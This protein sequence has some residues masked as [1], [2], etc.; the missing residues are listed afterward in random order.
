MTDI[1]HALRLLLRRPLFT[2]TVVGVLALGI[3]ANTAI[4]SLVNAVLLRPLPYHD[5]NR[6]VFVWN[7]RAG[8]PLS[9]GSHGVLTGTHVIN[10]HEQSTS[11]ASIA[12]VDSWRYN[13]APKVDLVHASGAERLRGAFVT[14]NFFELL[15][16]KAELGRTLESSDGERTPQA[17]VLSDGFWR[18]RFGAD[19]N[20]IG[21]TIDV[22]AGRGAPRGQRLRWTIVGVLPPTFRYT[23]PLET[24]VWGVLPWTRIQPDRALQYEMIAR[25]RDGVTPAQARADLTAIVQRFTRG[26][27]VPEDRVRDVIA[28]VELAPEHLV[29]EARP[30]IMLLVAGSGVV[31]LIA[32]VNVALLLLALITDRRREVAVR[33]ALGA[34]TLRITKQLLIESLMIAGLGGTLGC[35]IAWLG[36]PALASLVAPIAPRGDEMTIDLVALAF[37]AALSLGIAL[38]CGL[39]PAWH[40]RSTDINGQLRGAGAATTV[41]P[42]MRRWRRAIV[43][44]QVAVV[45]MLLTAASLLL[46]SFWRMQQVDLGYESSGIVT[47]EMRLLHP[48]FRQPGRMAA[49]QRDVIDRVRALPGVE[50]ASMTSA[51]PL[52]G[53]DFMNN[54]ETPDGSRAFGHMRPIDP[55]Y[56][57]LMRIP[58][59]AGR[60]FTP[61]DNETSPR[62]AILSAVF[63]QQ[64]FGTASPLGRRVDLGRAFAEV[65]GVV[66]DVR[67]ADVTKPPLAAIYFPRPQ[68]PS[69][70]ICLVVRPRPGADDVANQVRHAVAA[71]DPEQPV[72]NVSTLDRI[73][74]ESTA[75]ERFYTA[76]TSGFALVA[77]ILALAGLAGVVARTVSERV[78]E[79][80]IR[81]SLGADPGQLV[82]LAV[83]QGLTPALVGLAAGIAGAWATSRLLERFLFEV[84]PADVPTYATAAG[85]LLGAALLACYV[86]A[87]RAVR[88]E[89]LSILR[90]E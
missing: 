70:L 22:L 62:V 88:F 67:H 71:I 45:F 37:T 5:P 76:T 73:L 78:R 30:G 8:R 75:E 16:V 32:C 25:L 35:A 77:V 1:R 63:A 34:S 90:E 40:T 15:D 59:L 33:G 72:E 14:P 74:R 47:M 64:M 58:V 83:R 23:Y 79:M 21:T 26:Y 13:L 24:E 82:R 10:W 46:N 4:F 86:P 29:A 6:L 43:A 2:A 66:G 17:V 20:V 11:L 68:Q 44:A 60:A 31:M 19:P 69:E 89:P 48:K 28:Q 65:V 52:C 12:V 9:H 51:V 27:G 54:F 18:R 85:L 84:T 39:A 55:E 57:A 38:L 81:L 56:F 80:A 53:V 42:G 49:F 3:G 41:D 61:A 7:E 87:R 36:L 50:A